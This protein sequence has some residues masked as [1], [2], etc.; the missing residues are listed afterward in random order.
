VDGVEVVA[1]SAFRETAA[2]GPI[3]QGPYLNAAATLRCRLGARALLAAML[4]IEAAHG[5]DRAREQRWGPRRLDLDLLLY[6]DRVID[7]PGLTVPHPR[8][9]ERLFVLGPLAEIAPHAV[10]PVLGATVEQ[11]RDRLPGG[12]GV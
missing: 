10:H 5:R 3:G 2:Q 8:M 9:H 11:L 1:A 6:G 7:E 12:C 4:A